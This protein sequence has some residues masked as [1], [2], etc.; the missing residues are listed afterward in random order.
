MCAASN[1]SSETYYHILFLF[2][3]LKTVLMTL[4][5][6]WNTVYNTL[7]FTFR[8]YFTDKYDKIRCLRFA[9]DRSCQSLHC[10]R[11]PLFHKCLC[12]GDCF[13]IWSYFL[14]HSCRLWFVYANVKAFFLNKTLQKLDCFLMPKEIQHH[15]AHFIVLHHPPTTVVLIYIIFLCGLSCASLHGCYH[16]PAKLGSTAW[17]VLMELNTFCHPG[18]HWL[19]KWE[20]I[21]IA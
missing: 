9:S 21:W 20:R 11:W 4:N 16:M 1:T 3:P 19:G 18:V 10:Q 5:V 8:S 7:L 12:L 6:S 13:K 15:P 17:L 14:C 2:W